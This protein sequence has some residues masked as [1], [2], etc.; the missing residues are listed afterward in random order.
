MKIKEEADLSNKDVYEDGGK[1]IKNYKKAI[2]F[3]FTVDKKIDDPIILQ[4]IDM[5][6]KQRFDLSTLS[7]WKNEGS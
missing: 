4:L 7:G 2:F 3:R 1:V 6:T 5:E